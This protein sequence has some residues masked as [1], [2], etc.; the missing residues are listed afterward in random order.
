MASQS[1]QAAQALIMLRPAAFACNPQTL[2]SNYFQRQSN[3]REDLANRA[4]AEFDTLVDRLVNAGTDVR[5]FAGSEE[6]RLPDEVFPNNWFSTHG[7]GAVVLYPMLAPNRREER[8]AD[9]IHWL[10]H[11]STFSVHRIIDLTHFESSE[12]FLEGTGSLVLDHLH[13]VA[14]AGRSPRTSPTVLAAF[15]DELGFEVAAFDAFDGR[16]R[17]VFHTNMLMSLGNQ[18]AV[19][20]SESIRDAAQRTSIIGRIAATGRRIIDITI[21][22]LHRSAG[23][24]LEIATSAGPAIA[25]SN[26]VRNAFIPAQIRQ[27]EKFGSLV[28]ADISTIEQYGGGSVRCMLAEIHLPKRRE[29]A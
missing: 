9:I 8:R 11:E 19:L 29:A 2:E 14:Y 15:A 18:F 1:Q 12:D 26:A 3:G 17:P 28:T 24:I 10:E 4:R 6:K 5:V 25:M 20:C 23:N 16:G 27:L 13:R 7:D 22:Q 21:E